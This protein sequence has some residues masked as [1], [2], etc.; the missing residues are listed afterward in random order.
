MVGRSEF[1]LN[2]ERFHEVFVE[3]TDKS[4]SIVTNG[5]ARDPEPLDILHEGPGDLEAACLLH[6]DGFTPTTG[7]TEDREEVAVAVFG[8]RQRP[9]HI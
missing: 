2:V 5:H 4:V 8:H 6:R 1:D 9:Y 7:P 3:I